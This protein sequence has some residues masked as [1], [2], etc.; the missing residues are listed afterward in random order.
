MMRENGVKMVTNP[1]QFLWLA[2]FSWPH[3]CRE[4]AAAVGMAVEFV[5][6]Q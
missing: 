3:R 6:G 4:E 1:C 2:L 5:A